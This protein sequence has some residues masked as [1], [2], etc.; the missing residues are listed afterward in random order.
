MGDK[1]EPSYF[2]GTFRMHDD[3]RRAGRLVLEVAK[4]NKTVTGAYYSDKDG[5]KYEVTG[6]VGTPAH[7]IEFVVKY[8]RTEQVF[9]GMLFTGTG[10][11]M[12]GT[13]RMAERDA[14]FYATRE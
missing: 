9:K 4:D 5:Q 14:A 2:T 6:K 11:A 10:K 3:G 7:A 13:S 1:F 12:A 8:P